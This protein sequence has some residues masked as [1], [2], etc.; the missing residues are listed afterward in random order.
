[1]EGRPGEQG[2]LQRD[3]GRALPPVQAGVVHEDRGLR[4]QLAREGHI[5]VRERRP[6]SGP[7]EIDEAQDDTP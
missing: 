5:G 4:R 1:M 6:V 3:D 7:E 2:A